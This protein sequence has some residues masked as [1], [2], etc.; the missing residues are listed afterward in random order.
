MRLSRTLSSHLALQFIT[1][2]LV[3][4]AGLLSVVF[5][6]DFIELLRRASA[7]SFVP[8][9]VLVEMGLCKL[10]QM[11]ELLMP[12]AILFSAMLL[13]WRLQRSQ[14]LVAARAC[15]VSGWQFL[16]PVL[17]SAFVLGV[18]HITVLNPVAAAFFARFE[19]LENRYLRSNI[20]Q[21]SVAGSGLWLR[22]GVDGQET[23]IYGRKL[24]PHEFVLEDVT[25]FAFGP[26]ND[27][28]YRLDGKE[29][30]LES[31][32]WHMPEA[33]RL[34]KNGQIEAVKNV[35]ISTELTPSSLQDSF[36]SPETLSFWVLPE[37]IG[38]LQQA[39]LSALRH[40]LYWHSLL[41][42]P[43]LF[44][45]MVL[46]AATLSFRQQRGKKIIGLLVGGLF[47]GFLLFFFSDLI[48]ALGQSG[49]LPIVLAAWTPAVVA[50]LLGTT[51]VLHYEES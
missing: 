18:V 24:R 45:A 36:A 31:G 5:V 37:F 27:F 23:I 15:G 42:N 47:A 26:E 4:F 41:A 2:F 19:Q 49:R 12:F 29:A 16:T 8:I 34:Y 33:Y 28:L 25:V 6:F 21:L 50:L 51:L 46:I 13:F 22:Q 35:R 40:R 32:A 43:F 14:Q 44:C 30:S 7:K 9:D 11:G 17:V 10:P 48:G 38:T 20:S 39:G 1:T 3:V